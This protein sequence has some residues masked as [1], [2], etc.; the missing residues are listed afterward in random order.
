[1]ATGLP[2]SASTGVR[3]R[4]FLSAPVKVPRYTGVASSTASASASARTRR[5]AACGRRPRG[6]PAGGG[7]GVVGRPLGGAAVGEAEAVVR[8]AEQGGGAPGPR[9]GR[10]HRGL[11]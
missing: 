9:G 8:Q 11:H 3:S 10:V 7:G 5:G 6:G 1:M 4:R 2:R